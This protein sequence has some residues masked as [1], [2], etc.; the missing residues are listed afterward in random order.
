MSRRADEEPLESFEEAVRAEDE[1]LRPELERVA[2]D[3]A[4]YSGRLGAWSYL[5]RS[6]YAEQLERWFAL[7]PREQF[8]FVKTEDL[9]HSPQAALDAV[10]RFLG[11]PDDGRDAYP[12]FHAGHYTPMS[13]DTRSMLKEYFR[14]HNERL[15][16]L[17]GIDFGWDAEVGRRPAP[18]VG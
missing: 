4:C 13:A 12:S 15:Y 5:H 17:V 14:P 18:V 9:A 2:A 8:H 16:E 6:R 7:F 3:P 1:R 10:T 11:L